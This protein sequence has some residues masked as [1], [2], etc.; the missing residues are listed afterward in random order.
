VVTKLNTRGHYMKAENT[1]EFTE[2]EAIK[3]L[4]SC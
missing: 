1:F 3:C 4:V 2:G